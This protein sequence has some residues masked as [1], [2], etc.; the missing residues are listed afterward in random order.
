MMLPIIHILFFIICVYLSLNVLY[1]LVL[2]L[3]GLPAQKK[4][5]TT[6]HDKKRIAVLITTYM[7]DKVI[8]ATVASAARHD[9]P[10]DF[11]DVYVAAHRL[12][13]ET[14]ARLRRHTAQIM[15]VDFSSGS[16]A[17]SLNFLLNHI[18]REKYNIA[19]ILDGDNIMEHGFL[20]KINAAFQSGHRAVQA[21]RTAKNLDTPVAIL[22]A[23]SEEINN[24][25]F[26]RAPNN[27]GLSASLIGS[28]MAF[29]FNRLRDIYNKPGI[30]DN[31]ACDREVDFEIMRAGI[32]V[33]YLG[34][35][36]LLDEKVP[37]GNVYEKQRRRWLES[38]L[39]HL[40]LFFSAS[41]RSARKTTDFW[42]KLFVNLMLPRV[43]LSV[44][45]VCVLAVSLIEHFAHINIT[46]VPLRY[47]L[48]LLLIFVAAM[49]LALPQRY[50][51][52]R[53]ARALLHLPIIVFTFTRAAL[54]MRCNRKEF[55]HTPKS[56]TGN[57]NTTGK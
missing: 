34:N 8:E 28:G 52:G 27:L 2:S 23:M 46:N 12:Q 4:T 41:G 47:W 53:T 9:Y 3:A 44:L 49:L 56:F 37:T 40:G 20:E 11:F 13:P 31:P 48:T 25:L 36:V 18:D 21:H 1:L 30:I 43:L 33:A 32:R 15:E 22:D 35:A 39:M 45:L 5:F 38:Q 10:A 42:N 26:R 57:S 14:I 51:N 55:A 6:H 24:H 54:T 29:E 16:K 7:E 19:L 17:R 50:Y